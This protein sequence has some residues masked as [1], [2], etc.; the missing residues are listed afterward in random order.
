MT[1]SQIKKMLCLF[2]FATLPDFLY[3]A[4]CEEE[5][6]DVAISALESK[7]IKPAA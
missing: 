3:A 7:H 6:I 2:I 5:K 1:I 4:S